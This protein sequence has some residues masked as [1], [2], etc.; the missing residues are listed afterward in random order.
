VIRKKQMNSKPFKFSP[1]LKIKKSIENVEKKSQ[2]MA[3]K[4]YGY[5]FSTSEFY[6]KI[7]QDKTAVKKFNRSLNQYDLHLDYFPRKKNKNGK[8]YLDSVYLLVNNKT[9]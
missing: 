4:K 9:N 1:N 5:N 7:A 2:E 6:E 8:W 3:I